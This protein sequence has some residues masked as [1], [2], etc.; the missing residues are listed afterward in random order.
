LMGSRHRLPFQLICGHP[1]SFM[2]LHLLVPLLDEDEVENEPISN[3]LV[4][5]NGGGLLDVPSNPDA[6]T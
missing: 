3:D 5:S 6:G 1:A 2:N 4:L